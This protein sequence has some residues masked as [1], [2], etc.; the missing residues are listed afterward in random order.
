VMMWPL[1]QLRHNESQPSGVPPFIVTLTM[2]IP[3]LRSALRFGC[4]QHADARQK[5][6]QRA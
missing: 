3:F 2:T 6:G 5:V 1:A 4:S